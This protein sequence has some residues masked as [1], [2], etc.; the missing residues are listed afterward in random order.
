MLQAAEYENVKAD[1]RGDA[2][3][4][5]EGEGGGGSSEGYAQEGGEGGDGGGGEGEHSGGGGGQASLADFYTLALARL[6]TETGRQWAA[7]VNPKSS[8]L[9]L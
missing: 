7:E 3:G 9:T 2:G 6:K 4:G 5:S 8:T 1:V